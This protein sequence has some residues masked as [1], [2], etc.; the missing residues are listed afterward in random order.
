MN[1]LPDKTKAFLQRSAILFSEA[2]DGY[3]A[4]ICRPLMEEGNPVTYRYT[5]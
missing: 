5:F 4:T 3:S 1:A 2:G